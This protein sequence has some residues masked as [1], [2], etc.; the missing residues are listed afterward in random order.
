L[1]VGGAADGTGGDITHA[2]ALDKGKSRVFSRIH[3]DLDLS[4]MPVAAT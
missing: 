3:L 1:D 4:F 2:D